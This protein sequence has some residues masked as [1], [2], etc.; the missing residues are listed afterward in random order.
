MKRS[1]A[2]FL[3]VIFL[4]GAVIGYMYTDSKR[5]LTLQAPTGA[6]V[7]PVASDT[8]SIANF[9]IQVY[10]V[11][12]ADKPDVMPVLGDTIRNFDLVSIQE[13]RDSSNTALDA[14]LKEVNGIDGAY[15]YVVS[16]RLGRTSSKEQYAF[17]YNTSKIVFVEGSEFTFDDVNDDF[18]REPFFARFTAGKF[19]FYVGSLHTDPDDATHEIRSIGASID[20]V[21]RKDNILLVGDLNADCTYFDEKE[22]DTS[23]L[24]WLVPDDAD[25][26]VKSTICTYDRI[27]VNDG[28]KSHFTGAWGVYN[29]KD[30][31]GL[32]QL[33]AERVS[34]HFPVYAVFST[35]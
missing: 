7:L 22:K 34:D 32:S 21:P 16:P 9:N 8:I 24:T 10:G 1:F 12:K 28:A 17:L 23:G 5:N 33:Q 25:T 31:Q 4:V 11:S 18:H 27:L 13:I 15:A 3:L 19:S 14:L 26:T 2:A 20:A 29:F 6:V 35:D 30:E